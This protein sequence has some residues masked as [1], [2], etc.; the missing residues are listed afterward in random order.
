MGAQGGVSGVTSQSETGRLRRVLLKS[1]AAAFR[2]DVE[3]GRQWRALNYLSPP[4][5]SAARVEYES[6]VELLT[7]RGVELCFLPEHPDTGMDSLYVRDAAIVTDDGAILC[8]MGKPA[9]RGEPRASRVGMAAAGVEIRGAIDAPGTIEG[10]DVAWL[11][12][13]TLAVGRGYRT[14]AEGIRQLASLLPDDVALVEVPLPHW[15]GPED[16]FHLMSMLSPIDKDLLL[17]YSPLL[18][19]EEFETMGCN[20]LA[21]APRVCL[22]LEGNPVTR[23]RLEAAGSEVICYRGDE[24]S[25]KGC[26]GP[27]CLTRPLLREL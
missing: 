3:V 12:R 21:L 18:P 22:M 4:D 14:S 13:Q 10:G 16:V 7:A 20:V 1:P 8:R 15:H 11:D 27:T 9:R 19:V 2:S 6:L 5:L 25:R 17:V 26:G 24:I 23:R